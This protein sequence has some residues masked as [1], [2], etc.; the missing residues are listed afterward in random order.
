[1]KLD[2]FTILCHVHFNCR[3]AFINLACI[4]EISTEQ[5]RRL[6]SYQRLFLRVE[7]KVK[8]DL[9]FFSLRCVRNQLSKRHEVEMHAVPLI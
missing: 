8:A 3:C 1:M 7:E 2:F 6:S 5:L 4:N 9:I